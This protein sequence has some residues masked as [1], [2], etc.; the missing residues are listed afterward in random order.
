M[1]DEGS[2]SIDDF[3]KNADDVAILLEAFAQYAAWK[4]EEQQADRLTLN[5]IPTGGGRTLI[6]TAEFVD[7]S[8]DPQ[9]TDLH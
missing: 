8:E 3:D 6:I 1:S 5:C 2:L 4:I 9:F 7:G